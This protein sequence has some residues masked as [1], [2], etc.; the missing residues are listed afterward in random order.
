MFCGV[1]VSST[2]AT[3][4]KRYRGRQED[5]EWEQEKLSGKQVILSRPRD[6]GEKKPFPLNV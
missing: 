5:R 1:M 6:I 3:L 2:G 4:Q